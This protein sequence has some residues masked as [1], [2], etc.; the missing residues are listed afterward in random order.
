MT[1]LWSIP[2]QHEQQ[3][4][5]DFWDVV[6]HDSEVDAGVTLAGQE[7]HR[8]TERLQVLAGHISAIGPDWSK[9]PEHLSLTV[10]PV[11]PQRKAYLQQQANTVNPHTEEKTLR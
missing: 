11:A 10:C 2:V 1:H 3:G 5:I 6:S 9:T 7:N 8:T 4:L